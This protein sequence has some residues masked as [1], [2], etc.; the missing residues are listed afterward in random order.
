MTEVAGRIFFGLGKV[1]VLQRVKGM[2]KE[3]GIVLPGGVAPRLLQAHLVFRSA[4][5]RSYNR[6]RNG[7]GLDREQLQPI[8]SDEQKLEAALYKG[9]VDRGI[10]TRY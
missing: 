3:K 9:L 5:I 1:K 7:K 4:L 8:T 6:I 10:H 2:V